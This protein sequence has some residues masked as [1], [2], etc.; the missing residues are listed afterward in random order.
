[1]W[2]QCSD[3]WVQ[4]LKNQSDTKL[5]IQLLWVHIMIRMMRDLCLFLWSKIHL[6]TWCIPYFSIVKIETYSQ[7]HLLHIMLKSVQFF[8]NISLERS[9]RLAFVITLKF[10]NGIVY[11]SL[12]HPNPEEFFCVSFIVR[13]LS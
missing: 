13:L 7:T 8:M 10:F 11:F 6:S 4:N 3:C 9:L 1:M 12:R 2:C 5:Y